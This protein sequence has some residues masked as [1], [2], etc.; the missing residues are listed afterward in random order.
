MNALLAPITDPQRPLA[1][2]PLSRDGY[3][4]RA[5]AAGRAAAAVP[6]QSPLICESDGATP[7]DDLLIS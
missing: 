4:Q 3:S 7:D 5:R 1:W 2:S 6:M